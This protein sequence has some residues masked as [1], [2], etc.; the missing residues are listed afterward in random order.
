[1]KYAFGIAAFVLISGMALAQN[2]A[3]TN[4][5]ADPYLRVA[6]WAKMPMG[7][8]WGASAGVDHSRSDH[9]GIAPSPSP[10]FRKYESAKSMGGFR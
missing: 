8:F 9:R 7:R 6:N 3:P 4:N 10:F 5:A 1:M 2:N